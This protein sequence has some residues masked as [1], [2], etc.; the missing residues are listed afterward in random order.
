MKVGVVL[1]DDR[2]MESYVCA[3]FGQCS[4]F[5]IVDIDSENKKVSSTKVV[6]NPVSHGGGGCKGVDE[7]LKYGITH[8]LA[9]GMGMGAQ[10]KFTDAG[11]QIFGYE[12]LVKDGLSELVKNTLGGIEPCKD[13]GHHEGGCH[14]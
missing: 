9:G 8:V 7:I 5:L 11:V 1:E 10:M 14:H 13:H 6:S 3:H 4:F 12:G 2:G